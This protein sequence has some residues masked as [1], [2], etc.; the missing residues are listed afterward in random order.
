MKAIRFRTNT[1]KAGALACGYEE[2]KGD[3]V[4]TLDADLQDDPKEIPNFLRKLDEECDVVS[5]WK[6]KR[7]DPWHK[8][9]PSRVFN[10]MLSNLNGVQLHDH[11]CCFKCYRREVVKSLSMYGEMHR[12]V[13]SLARM[14]GF[15]TGEIPVL[16]H[17]RQ[18]G[19]S[20]YGVKRFLRGFMDMW[21]VYFL[22]NF[23]ERPL[24][25]MG[26]A[27]AS[28]FVLALGSWVLATMGF[29][30]GG[31][32]APALPIF[33]V[34]S[35]LLV[36]LG[37]MAELT[38]HR[39]FAYHHP[40]PVAERCVEKEADGSESTREAPK[41]PRVLVVDDDLSMRQILMPHFTQQN[42]EVIEAHDVESARGRI[43]EGVDLAL[44]DLYLPGG[45]GLDLLT[46]IRSRF[47]ETKVIILTGEQGVSVG[48]DAIKRG[49]TDYMTKPVNP[50]ELISHARAAISLSANFA[51]RS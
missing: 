48:V 40:L 34:A 1:G 12:M 51:T 17:A 46:E 21:T 37:V 30:M 26:S 50:S 20:K 22:N 3:V 38:V 6:R 43:S 42:W 10:K 18:F 41:T 14:N 44:L 24:H 23:K 19:E 31:V 39:E 16:H 11:N 9:L 2:A 8:V 33:F 5:R 13:P 4:F 27:A 35:V 36:M 45:T 15:R 25:L 7:H 32:L 49:A 29:T 47:P 28:M